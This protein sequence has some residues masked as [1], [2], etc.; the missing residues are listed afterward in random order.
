MNQLK[1]NDMQQH[2]TIVGRANI[3]YREE[4]LASL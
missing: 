4:T 2:V 1:Q 3:V